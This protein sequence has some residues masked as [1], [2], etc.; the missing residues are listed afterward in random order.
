LD[1]LKIALIGSTRPG[2]NGT[3]VASWV[4]ELAVGRTAARYKIV[5]LDDRN[6]LL[7]DA[8]SPDLH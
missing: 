8:P 2:R 6:M 4:H 7:L 5:D 3:A 1:P